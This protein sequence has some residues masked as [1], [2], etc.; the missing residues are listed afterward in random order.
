MADPPDD[1]TV[2]HLARVVESSD[3]AIIS[4]NLDGVITSWNR[5][6]ERMFG[7]TATEAVGR[8]IRI[9]IPADRQS[10]EDMVIERVRAGQVVRHLE[11]RRQR[12]DGTLIPISLTVSPIHDETGQ[13]IGASKI[14]R[15]ISDRVDAAVA[16]RRLVAIVESTDDAIVSKDLNGVIATW[17][18]AAERMFGYTASEV[19]GQ[20]IRI[21]IPADRQAEE[22]IVLGRIAAGRS[23]EHFETIRQRKRHARSDLVD[24]VADSRRRRPRDW[25]VEDRAGHQRARFRR[26]GRSPSRRGHRILR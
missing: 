12:K 19:I 9:I 2:R 8:S 25:R 21:I 5:A 26:V 3:D 17:N 24:G 4:K 20:S 6:A 16:N 11:T 13:V 10:E 14:A 23:V 18:R 15:D 22:D 7:F 1:L